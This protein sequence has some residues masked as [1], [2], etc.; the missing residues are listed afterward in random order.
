MAFLRRVAA[1][2]GKTLRRVALFGGAILMAGFASG[3]A[4]AQVLGSGTGPESG[5]PRTL[6]QLA[7]A[8]DC[9]PLVINNK[10][11]R[12]G[13]CKTQKGH[14]VLVTFASDK[15]KEAWLKAAKPYGGHYLVGIRWVIVS[16]VSNLETFRGDLG[17]QIQEG[18]KHGHGGKGRSNH[19]QKGR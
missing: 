5:E 4:G 15:G 17:G 6:E 14:I 9:K 12:Q 7:A 16:T 19:Q 8:V 18:D 2:D 1:G 10:E 13:N 11:L 3:Y